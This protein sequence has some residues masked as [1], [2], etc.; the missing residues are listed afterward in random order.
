[1]IQFWS[2]GASAPSTDVVIQDNFFDQDAGSPTQSIFMRNE[3]VDSGHA[4]PEMFYQNITIENNV[5]K[6]TYANGIIVGEAVAW[7]SRTIRFSRTDPTAGPTIKVAAA[8]QNVVITDNVAPPV[9]VFRRRSWVV[10]NNFA[11]QND[12]PDAPNYYGNV[13]VNPFAHSGSLADLKILPGSVLDQPGLG[14]SLLAFDQHPDSL[15]GFLLDSHGD[16]LDLSTHTL[17]ASHL[18]GPGGVVDAANAS[19]VWDFGDGSSGTGLSASHAYAHAG[20]YSVSAN[21]TLQDGEVT[22]LTR[23]IDVGTPVALQVDFNGN[24]QDHSDVVTPVTVG[25]AVTF[26]N[27]VDGQAVRLNGDTVAYAAGPEF[28]NNPEFTVVF[29]FKKDAGNPSEPPEPSFNSTTAVLTSTLTA[30]G[31]SATVNT[32]AGN[33][34]VSAGALGI[35]DSA[36]HQVALTFSGTTRRGHPLRRRRGGRQCRWPDRRNRSGKQRQCFL[37]RRSVPLPPQAFPVCSTTSSSSAA[38]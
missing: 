24:A 5:I 7:S 27:G 29:D 4:G 22:T 12:N 31:V 30:N 33:A 28:F 25:D 35:D 1:M 23:T 32:D 20:T 18:F 26:E 14:S 16:G 15:T 3:K 9:K 21:V 19:V 17:D 34:K 13:F 36:W 37:P 6:N 2:T 38:R 11:I 8:S 10:E